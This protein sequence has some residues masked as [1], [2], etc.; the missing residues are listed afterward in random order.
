M[1]QTHN[2][3]L[4]IFILGARATISPFAIDMYRSAFPKVAM[5]LVLASLSRCS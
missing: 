4:M 5:A 2:R 1:S 3:P